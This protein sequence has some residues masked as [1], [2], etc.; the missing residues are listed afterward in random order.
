MKLINGIPRRRRVDLYTSAEKAIAGAMAAVEE[1]GCHPLLTEAVNLLT[2]AKEKV[3]DYVELPGQVLLD[4]KAD[5]K[6]TLEKERIDPAALNDKIIRYRGFTIKPKLDFGTHGYLIDGQWVK[7]GWVVCDTTGFC[8]MMPAAT[9]FRTI[10]T[11]VDGI[12]TLIESDFDADVFWK[13]TQEKATPRPVPLDDPAA[14]KTARY[15]ER[16]MPELGSLYTVDEFKRQCT[17][18]TFVAGDGFGSPIKDGWLDPAYDVYPSRLQEIPED[19]THILW[20]NK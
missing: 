10:D 4:K 11:A 7:T 6:M 16:V 1:A 5:T 8:N 18:G 17:I 9:W 2:K 3:A 13:L 20:Y 15:R 12:D 14:V 19:A